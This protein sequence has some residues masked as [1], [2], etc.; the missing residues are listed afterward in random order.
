MALA[1]DANIPR[2]GNRGRS[3]FGYP[4]APG[5]KVYRGSAVALNA[6]GQLQRVQTA[7][8]VVIVGLSEQFFDNTASA[9]ASTQLVVAEPGTYALNVTGA[10]PSVIHAPVYASDDNTFTM[11]AGS[12]L[13][14]GVLAGIESGQDYVMTTGA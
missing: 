8:S 5:E 6:A 13:Q 9:T 3:I 1:A 7:G 2:R 14:I 4:V 12:L 11:T 10:T